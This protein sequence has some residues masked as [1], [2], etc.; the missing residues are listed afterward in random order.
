LS[1][2]LAPAAIAST[3]QDRRIAGAAALVAGLGFLPQPILVFL[4]SAPDG[5]EYWPADRLGELTLRTTIQAVTWGLFAAGLI[6]LVATM[7]RML[8]PGSWVRIGT[9]FGTIGGAAWLAES[10]W[11]LAT[12]SQPADHFA[13]APVD[14]ATQGSILYLLTLADF[15]WTA[16]GGIGAGLWL[17]MLGTAGAAL[18]GR[19]LGI[20]AI[21]VGAVTVVSVYA[22]PMFPVGLF[23]C[24][25]L[26][27]VL[28]IVLLA[29]GR[30]ATRS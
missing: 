17:V 23:L 25:L 14:A 28:G 19:V 7:S 9:A 15:G 2:P 29:G 3:A 26:W 13:T 11:R 16:L 10:A 12:L 21:I 5:S 4:L 27:I 1:E 6:V 20:V 24:Y 30:R 18:T 22:A 8:G